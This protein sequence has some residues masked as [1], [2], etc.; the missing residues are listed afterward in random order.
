MLTRLRI[1]NFALIES[2]DIEFGPGLNVITG[3]TGAGKSI[4]IGA[5]N[6][7]LGGPASADLV[8]SGADACAVEG[9]FELDPQ[10]PAVRALAASGVEAVDGQ[11][12]LRREIRA[13][14]R[15]RAFANQ[16]LIPVRALRQLGAR[17]VDLH[18]Q[19]EHQSLLDPDHH[20][21]FLDESGGLRAEAEAV[22]ATCRA[23]RE[24]ADALAALKAERQGLR[25]VEELHQYQLEEIRRLAP[26]PGE[27]EA[28]ESEIQVLEH[29]TELAQGAGGLYEAL[30]GDEEATV[31]QLGRARREL[32][33]LAEV[34]PALKSWADAVSEVLYRLEDVAEGLREYGEGLDADPAR[35]VEAHQRLDELVRLR[36][37][38]GGNMEAVLMRAA[39]LEAQ[40]ERSSGLDSALNQAVARREVL[41]AE[42]AEACRRLSAGRQRAAAELS[43]QVQTR[44][45]AL[46]MAEA[47]FQVS[48]SR[49]AAEDGL[50]AADGERYRADERGMEAVEFH[51]SANQGERLL[52]LASVASGGEISRIMLVLK[53]IIA[54]RDTVGS[55]V[56]DEIDVG[57]SGRVAAAVG[58][59]LAELSASHQTILITH[60][61]QIASLADHHFAVRKRREAGRTTTEVVALEAAERTDEIAQLMAGDTVSETARRHAREMLE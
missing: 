39:E 20:A 48:L 18:G 57:I 49:A 12:V 59:R 53:S 4:L 24:S 44:L 16:Q 43:E 61:P 36:Q 60:L 10:G 27:D 7:I 33:R 14:G 25:E 8:R 6:S 42:F 54:E 58:R 22:A 55:L 40:E 45:K 38:H 5:L 28:L 32:E 52:P 11:L 19:H 47:V 50:A 3:E 13:G 26:K 9:L 35:L 51:I 34:D 21:R 1:E 2:A 37:R 29:Q 31:T 30:Y 41:L 17:L 23:C 46:G 56:F 15:S